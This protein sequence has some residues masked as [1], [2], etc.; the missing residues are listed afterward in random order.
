M[1][2]YLKKLIKRTL[3]GHRSVH[4]DQRQ[5][6]KWF[7]LQGAD[8][9]D[10]SL[11]SITS[12]WPSLVVGTLWVSTPGGHIRQLASILAIQIPQWPDVGTNGHVRAPTHDMKVQVNQDI[13]H[14]VTNIIL[15]SK[16]YRFPLY[17]QPGL[18]LGL[19]S[20]EISVLHSH[21][22]L[23]FVRMVALRGEVQILPTLEETHWL[24]FGIMEL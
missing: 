21:G 5:L 14:Q 19:F 4:A 23:S 3:F 8:T 1:I 16:H 11:D 12:I 6:C 22:W 7:N 2:L 17:L 20:N 18:H 13:P 15:C 9:E 10:A 24:Y